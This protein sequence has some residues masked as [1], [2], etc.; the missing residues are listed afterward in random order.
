MI[1]SEEVVSIVC[2]ATFGED[3][4]NNSVD[5]LSRVLVAF[6]VGQ[7]STLVVVIL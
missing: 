7:M 5:L 1:M 2:G 6:S 4:V 3:R